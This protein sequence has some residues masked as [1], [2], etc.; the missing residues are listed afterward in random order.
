MKTVLGFVWRIWQA[1]G[2]IS[3]LLGGSI[4]HTACYVTCDGRDK[5]QLSQASVDASAVLSREQ[6]RDS[7]LNLMRKKSAS[8]VLLSLNPPS[9]S[10]LLGRQH[11]YK[12]W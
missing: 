8:F 7:N 12:L 11:A 10:F 4:S 2:P 3:E 1:T 5:L 6:S 9:H